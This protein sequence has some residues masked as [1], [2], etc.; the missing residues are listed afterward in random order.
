M[1]LTT[2]SDGY[3]PGHP[4]TITQGGVTIR[5][6]PSRAY[7]PFWLRVAAGRWEAHTLNILERFNS[8]ERTMLDIGAWIGPTTLF[9]AHFAREVL[10]MEPDPV[11]FNELAGNVSLNPE[12][13]SSIGI[14]QACLALETGPVPIYAGGFHHAASSTFGDSMTS[15]LPCPDIEKQDSMNVHG[16]SIEDVESHY[17]FTDLGLVKM[18]V[19]GGEYLLLPAMEPFLARHRPNLYA[20]FHVPPA[21]YRDDRIREAFAV[22]ARVYPRVYSAGGIEIP[23]DEVLATTTNWADLTRDNPASYLMAIARNGLLATFETW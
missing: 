8:P 13:G 7:L 19:E 11:A 12:I 21:A 1:T 15:L 6:T 20:S 5:V 23:L 3:I 4:P 17:D 2:R 10:A 18:D 9:G 16:I 14:V 22:L